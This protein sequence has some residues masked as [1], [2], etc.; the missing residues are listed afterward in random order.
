M[1]EAAPLL[2]MRGIVKSFPASGRYAAWSLSL[3]PG[4]VL[5]L[6]GEN[7]AG[8]STL[9]KVLGG[10]HPADEG[11]ILIDGRP[12]E[13]PF[14]A[15]FAAGRDRGHL[16]GVQSHPGLTACENIFLGQEISRAG[17]IRRSRSGSAQ[18]SYSSGSVWRSTSMLPAAG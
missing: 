13:F 3:R 2:E 18:R 11:E 6:L 17:F 16:P 14:A 9:M 8:K 5:A 7:G 4:E 10:A 15:R 1:S 12:A